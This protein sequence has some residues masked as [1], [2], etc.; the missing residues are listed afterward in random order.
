MRWGQTF[1]TPVTPQTKAP[2]P[3]KKTKQAPGGV[4]FTE[5]VA[6]EPVGFCAHLLGM[7]HGLRRWTGM[8]VAPRF[9]ALGFGGSDEVRPVEPVSVI[10]VRRSSGFGPGACIGR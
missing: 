6:H 4:A 3:S 10:G 9:A 5:N 7:G 1:Q 8:G 2:G